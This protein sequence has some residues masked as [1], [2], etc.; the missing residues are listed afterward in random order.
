MELASAQAI[1]EILYP[2]GFHF[3]KSMG[4]NFLINPSV[5]ERIAAT[6]PAGYGVVEVGPGLGALTDRLSQRAEKLM[7]VELDD[8]L[9]PHL[10]SYF[11]DRPVT[12]VK[13][14][15]LKVDLPTLVSEHLPG[16]PLVAYANLPYYITTP[17]IEVLME[18]GLFES[19]TLMVQKE[20]A[21]RITT[22]PGSTD[23]SYHTVYWQYMAEPKIL[24]NVSP[25][26]F[27]PPPKVDSAVVSFTMRKEPPVPVK[28]K[29]AFFKVVRLA[30]DN[31]RKT[32]SNALSSLP[33]G[34]EALAAS[35]VD[36]RRRGD[37]LSI[38]EFAAIANL[39][40]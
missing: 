30:F 25:G 35:G 24:F 27:L 19:I 34:K 36:P 11:R 20:V 33:G 10:E 28:D 9:L 29:K 14:D 7:A 6:L 39:I 16:L 37:T 23:Y 31:R 2:D 13:G 4:Q 26:S 5:P 3:S 18:S 38:P 12:I 22:T 17:A 15:V 40:P 8:R 32:M 1:K 21:K